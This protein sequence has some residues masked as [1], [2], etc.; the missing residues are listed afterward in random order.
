MVREIYNSSGAP[1]ES[2]LYLVAPND[3][4]RPYWHGSVPRVEG[5]T[6]RAHNTLDR[7]RDSIK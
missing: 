7:Y 3:G 6:M 4:A 1:T 2:P 5:L